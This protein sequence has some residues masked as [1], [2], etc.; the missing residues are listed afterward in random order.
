M[1]KSEPFQIEI[2]QGQYSFELLPEVALSADSL[3]G[4][5]ENI[6]LLLD[7]RSVHAVLV[8][9]DHAAKE[10]TFRI[11]G[12]LYTAR[13]SDHYARLIH[14][15]GLSVGKS[16]QV[17]AVKAPMPGLVLNIL[18]SPGETVQKGDVLLILEAMKMENVIKA[19]GDATVKH[20]AVSKGAA[21]EKG[22]LLIEMA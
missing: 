2:N 5:E 7:G 9:A 19:A 11:D 20:I 15:L 17:N 1:H 22:Q 21:V 10:Y 16:K 4:Q 18:V 12:M 14:Q 6:H 3:P 13:I 8:A